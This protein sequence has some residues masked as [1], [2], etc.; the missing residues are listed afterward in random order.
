MRVLIS[1]MKPYLGNVE[2]NME[3]MV[4]VIQEGID[5]KC[6][7][8]VF[9]ELALN[10]T[11]LGDASFDV[12]ISSIPVKLREMSNEI[13]II[14]G[15][16]EEEKGKLY[17]SAYV[18]EDGELI[19]KHRKTFLSNMNGVCE[20][21]YFTKGNEIKVIVSKYGKF[22][23]CLGEEM[24]NPV[25]REILSEAGAEVTFNLVNLCVSEDTDIYEGALKSSSYYSKNFNVFVNRVGVEDGVTF[26]G[27]SFVISPYG[28][29]IE[30]I[31]KFIEKSS[32]I[33]IDL[34][35]IK[36]ASFKS[37]FDKESNLSILYKE[38]GK[39]MVK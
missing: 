38:F 26:S 15:A 35:F 28:K 4:N 17:N 10:G 37:S 1:Q 19:G 22:G 3:K 6:E 31:E 24:L 34:N 27:N 32:I 29:N 16:V 5:K 21:R 7:V 9:P 8:V 18:I 11:I 2:K 39:I 36:K 13:T 25:I 33:D 12:C 23:I 14:F 20:S 30:K